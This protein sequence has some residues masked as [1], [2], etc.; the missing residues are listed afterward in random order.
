LKTGTAMSVPRILLIVGL[1]LSVL[2]GVWYFYFGRDISLPWPG[3]IQKIEVCQNDY[4]QKAQQITYI[5]D[6]DRINKVFDFIE[7]RRKGWEPLVYT[8]PAAVVSVDFYGSDGVLFQL[9]LME[10]SDFLIRNGD[11][12]YLKSL[13]KKELNEFRGLLGVKAERLASG[14]T[15]SILF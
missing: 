1:F 12:A 8:P 3:Q 2:A 15:P 13:K 9:F 11:G 4:Q 5:E 10:S 7:K 14:K 6:R